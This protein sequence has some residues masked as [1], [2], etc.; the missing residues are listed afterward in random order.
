M[1]AFDEIVK[2]IVD[3]LEYSDEYEYEYSKDLFRNYSGVPELATDP[4]YNL[5]NQTHPSYQI[6]PFMWNFIERYPFDT[7]LVQMSKHIVSL[8]Y[9][10]LESSNIAHTIDT[11]LGKFG[12]VIDVWKNNIPDFTGYITKYEDS[13]HIARYTGRWSE[14]VGYE[15]A[16]YP[17]ALEKYLKSQS[18]NSL[19]AYYS[20]LKLDEDTSIRSMISNALTTSYSKISD[21]ACMK[22]KKDVF[23]IYKYYVDSYD[24]IYI[25]YKHYGVENPSEQ[26]KLLTPG[27]LWIRLADSPIAFPMNKV[28]DMSESGQVFTLLDGGICDIA[29][30]E[31]GA[32]LVITGFRTV[33]RYSYT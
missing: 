2:S 23:D 17:P 6:H 12:N 26:E 1:I 32:K 21:I 20:H 31:S 33:G 18:L 14:V 8:S 22:Q 19:S 7:V 5:K 16:F 30:F 15:G 3:K 28:V 24:N 4:Y 10:V 27:E 11:L 25:L 29:M 13:N 9:D